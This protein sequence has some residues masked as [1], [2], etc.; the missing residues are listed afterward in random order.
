MKKRLKTKKEGRKD[1]LMWECQDFYGDFTLYS[2][3]IKYAD[4]VHCM[5][6]GRCPLGLFRCSSLPIAEELSSIFLF[7]NISI[8]F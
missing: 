4:S 5:L 2:S 7:F 3:E 6:G 8:L 1:G